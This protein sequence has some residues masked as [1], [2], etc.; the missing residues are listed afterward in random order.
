MY[1]FSCVFDRVTCW[2]HI[3]VL[4]FFMF[5]K[6]V[7]PMNMIYVVFM[8]IELEDVALTFLYCIDLVLKW[9]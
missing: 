8:H 3:V 9:R 2:L 7:P 5:E 4:S 6:V 1:M